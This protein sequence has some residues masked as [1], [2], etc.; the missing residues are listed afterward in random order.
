MGFQDFTHFRKQLDKDFKDVYG[1]GADEH[2]RGFLEHALLFFTSL[3]LRDF[4]TDPPGKTVPP[5][6]GA[7]RSFFQKAMEREVPWACSPQF[8][9]SR[10]L[11]H[12]NYQHYN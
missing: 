1:D 4:E 12:L 8:L 11:L 3:A 9:A 5:Y 2:F 7:I 6:L 10:C